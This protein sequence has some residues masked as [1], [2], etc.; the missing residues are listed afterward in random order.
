MGESHGW[1]NMWQR[2]IGHE[3]DETEVENRFTEHKLRAK[4]ASDASTLTQIRRSGFEFPAHVH[5]RQ[6]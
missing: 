1:D 5:L 4:C 3:I 2:F 6:W